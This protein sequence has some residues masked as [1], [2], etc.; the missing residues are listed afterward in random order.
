MKLA[1]EGTVDGKPILE[2]APDKQIY[3]KVPQTWEEV[4]GQNE[5]LIPGL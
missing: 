2:L 5:G 3:G 1:Y 4:E